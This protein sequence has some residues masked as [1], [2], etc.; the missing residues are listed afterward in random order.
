M[1]DFQVGSN[2]A[3]IREPSRNDP[4]LRRFQN[5]WKSIFFETSFRVPDGSAAALR[6]KGYQ[7]VFV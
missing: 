6:I 1:M 2:L 7:F 4:V 5:T 3:G